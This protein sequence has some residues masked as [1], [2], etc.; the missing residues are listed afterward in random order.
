MAVYLDHGT[1]MTHLPV[2]LEEACKCSLSFLHC[3]QRKNEKA[4]L[5]PREKMRNQKFIQQ[6]LSVCILLAYFLSQYM[7]K[8]K[9]EECHALIFLSSCWKIISMITDVNLFARGNETSSLF[10]VFIL[11]Y[12]LILFI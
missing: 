9:H 10:Y 3:S 7:V 11:F 12:S 5:S 8:F 1:E 4:F 2:L 6:L